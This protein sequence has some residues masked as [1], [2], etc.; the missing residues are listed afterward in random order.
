MKQLW[1][2]LAVFVFGTSC[3][4]SHSLST[5]DPK[6]EISKE[7]NGFIYPLTLD[8]AFSF[9]INPVYFDS[10][11]RSKSYCLNLYKFKRGG[12]ASPVQI[13]MY[14]R[15]GNLVGGWEQCYGDL[16]H[17]RLFDSVPIK[18]IPWH[19]TNYEITLHNDLKLILRDGKNEEK[20]QHEIDT[21]DY[22]IIVFYTAWAGWYSRDAIK[23]TLKYVESNHNI[24]IIYLNTANK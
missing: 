24:A 12:N 10:L 3:S 1:Y 18:R 13:R 11:S 7:F 9:Q 19:P 23:R 8:T 17:F 5:S 21:H 2:I 22:T 4:L 15:S 16:N 20:I 14:E 6:N